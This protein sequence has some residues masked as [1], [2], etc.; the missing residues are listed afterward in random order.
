MFEIEKAVNWIQESN[1]ITFALGAG[2]SVASG[3]PTFRGPAGLY[4]MVTKWSF[5]L[6]CLG[7]GL[8]C[9]VQ[10]WFLAGIP[11]MI[12]FY[13]VYVLSG[14][15]T[16]VAWVQTS[17]VGFA[18]SLVSS[19]T[20]IAITALLF[21]IYPTSWLWFGIFVLASIGVLVCSVFLMG[22]MVLGKFQGKLAIFNPF[23]TRFP[24]VQ[25]RW[26]VLKFFVWD[27]CASANPNRGHLAISYLQKLFP[28]KYV[29]VTTMNVDNLER[30]AGC[31]NV[32]QQHGQYQIFQCSS[33]NCSADPFLYTAKTLPWLPMKC[34][35]CG[36]PLRTGMLLFS[37]PD[38]TSHH[39][40]NTGC[41]TQSSPMKKKKSL[42]IAIGISG[43]IGAHGWDSDRIIELNVTDAGVFF[44]GPSQ[45][46]LYIKG[47][48][49]RTM[50]AII[51]ILQA[52]TTI[53]QLKNVKEGNE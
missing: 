12:G 45:D 41:Q 49:D 19:P 37:D 24:L 22:S 39:L 9:R 36:N 25:I 26:L 7:F 16:E 2:A 18:K 50:E 52:R 53:P 23:L 46:Y 48:Q 51:R 33:R 32:R 21:L 15:R 10:C 44:P 43:V 8:L 31:W 34:A 29:C 11:A 4:Y 6:V 30:V 38:N 14:D 40:A 27:P 35:K 5:F 20:S 3:I 17:L 42:T 47:E 13:C 28:H 1:H